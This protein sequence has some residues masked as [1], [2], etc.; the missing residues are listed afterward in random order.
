MFMSLL[1]HFSWYSSFKFLRPWRIRWSLFAGFTSKDCF[2]FSQSSKLFP[3]QMLNPPM[4]HS[5]K[6]KICQ[7]NCRCIKSFPS[8]KIRRPECS[9]S[10]TCEWNTVTNPEIHRF[11]SSQHVERITH[12]EWGH[13]YFGK[14]IHSWGWDTEQQFWSDNMLCLLITMN[15]EGVT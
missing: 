15:N 6:L 10:S 14:M 9:H 3:E 7:I 11:L 5:M 2:T 12:M 13:T 1:K 4:I 8:V